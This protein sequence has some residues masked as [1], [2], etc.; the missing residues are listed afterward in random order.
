MDIALRAAD[1]TAMGE[2][3]LARLTEYRFCAVQ[4]MRAT[5]YSDLYIGETL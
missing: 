2:V 4:P 5:R 3:K 1:T